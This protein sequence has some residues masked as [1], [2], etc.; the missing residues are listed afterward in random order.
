MMRILQ[1]PPAPSGLVKGEHQPNPEFPVNGTARMPRTLPLQEISK[2]A[3]M[4]QIM[5]MHGMVNKRR[6]EGEEVADGNESQP[7]GA[8]R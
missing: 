4:Q 2:Q 5:A 7:H 6:R 8:S 1:H 3:N